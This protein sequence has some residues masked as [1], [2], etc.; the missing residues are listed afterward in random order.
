MLTRK[1]GCAKSL[2]NSRDSKRLDGENFLMI[3]SQMGLLFKWAG[4]NAGTGCGSVGFNWKSKKNKKN[5]KSATNDSDKIRWKMWVCEN[6]LI[7]S[8]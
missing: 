4:R 6:N 1:C 5:T 8:I 7:K 2:A 3:S